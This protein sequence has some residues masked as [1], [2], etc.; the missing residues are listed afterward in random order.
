MSEKIFVDGM[1]VDELVF[2]NGGS[3]L[4]VGINVEKLIGFLNRHRNE[5]GYVNIDICRSQKQ[6]GYHSH[7]AALNTFNGRRRDEPPPEQ[8]PAAAP[9]G[10]GTNGDPLPY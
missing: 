10:V 8:T 4:K 3:L 5:R 1:S 9:A 2:Q 7:Y 6:G